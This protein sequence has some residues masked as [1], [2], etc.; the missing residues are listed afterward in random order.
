MSVTLIQA[1]KY[2]RLSVLI[3]GVFVN[4]GCATTQKGKILE[5]TSV[6]SALGASYGATRPD[7]QGQNSLMFGAVGAAV[8]ALAG[9]YY[10]DPDKHAENLMAENQ[11]LQ[12]ELDAMQASKVL[13]ES[14]AMFN[15]KIPDKYKKLINPGEWR[16]SEIDQWVEESENRLIHQDKIMELVPPTLN[17][18]LS[19][20][21]DKTSR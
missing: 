5:W 19:S 8:G 6:G 21:R 11:K 10:H 13:V 15:T 18:N 20:Q 2:F 4:F 9:L 3:F 7:Y 16:I 12:K 14:P 1:L 17:P